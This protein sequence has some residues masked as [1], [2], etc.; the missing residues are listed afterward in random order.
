MTRVMPPAPAP[1]IERGE[2][3]VKRETILRLTWSD[4]SHKFEGQFNKESGLRE[5]LGEET[6]ENGN[7]YEG[8]YANDMRHGQG[9]MTGTDGRCYEG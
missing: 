1:N 5:G 9:K 2:V 6:W 4:S 3:E 7:V 8:F